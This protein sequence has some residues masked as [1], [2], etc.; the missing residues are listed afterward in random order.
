MKAGIG[1]RLDL[2]RK[3]II[4]QLGSKLQV[5][6]RKRKQ[7]HMLKRKCVFAGSQ[8]SVIDLCSLVLHHSHLFSALIS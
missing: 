1:T 7:G 4:L 3:K 5:E 6:R 2:L 8:V